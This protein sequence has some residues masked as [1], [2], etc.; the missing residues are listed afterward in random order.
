MNTGATTPRVF[1]DEDVDPATLT[2]E[3]IAVIGYGIQGRAQALNLRDAG[4]RVVVGNRRDRYREQAERDGFV[5]LD[6]PEAIERGTIVLFL[7]PDEV[8]PQVFRS[9]IRPRLVPGHALMFAHGFA[10]RYG[11]VDPPVGVDVMLLA[12]RLPGQYV[13]GRFVDGWGVPA[14]VAVERDATG[15]A[16]RRLLAVARGIGATRAAAI[17]SSFA[18]ETELD[19]F[20]EHFLYPLVFAAVE[21]AFEALVE[22]GYAREVALMELYGSGEL[23]QVLLAAADQ[24]LYQMIRSHASPA[25]QAGIAHHWDSA[26][27]DRNAVRRRIADVIGAIRDGS[28][29]RHL[30][31][32]QQRDYPELHTWRHQRSTSL[33][34]AERSLRR[35]VRRPRTDPLRVDV[36]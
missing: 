22:A 3:T 27:G 32:E 13:R 17:E 21:T 28:F 5:V 14:F 33:E 6:I 20:S 9:D 25:C 15:R 11:L 29:A 26:L 35:I 34:A 24:G 10:I 30:I 19:H 2:S 8:Q 1:Y 36:P 4:A 16:W 12:P 23:G 18:E 7:L 31:E